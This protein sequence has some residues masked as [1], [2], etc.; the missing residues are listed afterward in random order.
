MGSYKR[1]QIPSATGLAPEYHI[2]EKRERIF[3]V[4]KCFPVWKLLYML[5]QVRTG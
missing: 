2:V 1:K 3:L 5:D 4:S